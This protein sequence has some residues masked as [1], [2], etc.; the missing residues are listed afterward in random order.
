M[1]EDEDLLVIVGDAVPKAAFDSVYPYNMLGWLHQDSHCLGISE[2]GTLIERG[3]SGLPAVV[4]PI[5]L[6]QIRHSRL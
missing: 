1:N 6:P 3:S 5:R 2:H 4:Q